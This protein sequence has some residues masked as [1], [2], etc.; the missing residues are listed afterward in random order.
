MKKLLLILTVLLLCSCSSAPSSAAV[1]EV[2]PPSAAPSQSPTPVPQPSED[3]QQEQ[4]PDT[5]ALRQYQEAMEPYEDLE[6]AFLGSL[7]EENSFETILTRAGQHWPVVR[8]ITAERIIQGD[9]GDSVQY[10]YLLVPALH[11]DLQVG[12]YSYYAGEITETWF[13]EKDALPLIYI[14]SG[15]TIDPLG[16]IRYVRHF[17]DGDSE[18]WLYTG[19]QAV[20]GKLRTDYHMGV[21]DT[22]VYELYDSTEIPFYAQSFFDT[23]C[24]YEEVAEAL[25]SGKELSVMEEM[26]WDGHAY[27]VYGIDKGDAWT[28]YGVTVNEDGMPS[29]IVSY[30]NGANWGTLGR[31]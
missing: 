2:A 22:T 18:G 31:G 3:T 10:V 26:L 13:E 16:Q 25:N 15:D 30:D 4:D 8:N 19:L 11:T 12:R 29:V 9:L 14:E 1:I 24:S 23:L 20:S 6:I 28:L 17:A 5:E 27:A 7:H 21:V